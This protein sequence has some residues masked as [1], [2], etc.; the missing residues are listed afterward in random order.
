[1]LFSFTKLSH[2][3]IDARGR[4]AGHHAD[5]R[6]RDRICCRKLRH[7]SVHGYKPQY[8][9]SAATDDR[10]IFIIK[11]CSFHARTGEIAQ[12]SDGCDGAQPKYRNI[13]KI[14]PP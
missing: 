12:H 4:K 7:A 10:N 5:S 1:M 8:K 13:R 11:R 14:S 3:L 9:A 2:S 6:R